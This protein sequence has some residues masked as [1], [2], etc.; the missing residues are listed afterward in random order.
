MERFEDDEDGYLAWLAAHPAGLV[1]NTHRPEDRHYLMLHR[2]T[3]P[4]ISSRARTNYTTT[5]YMKVCSKALA[6]L[7]QWAA[8]LDGRLVP[9]GLC[10]PESGTPGEALEERDRPVETDSPKDDGP[11]GARVYRAGP[12]GS[13]VRVKQTRLSGGTY[14]IDVDASGRHRERHCD[15]TDDAALAGAVRDALDGRLTSDG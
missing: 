8:S 15:S 5:G 11:F 9:C 1:V 7:E 10:C 2:A 13:R 12:E 4:S 14:I 6:A 3:C